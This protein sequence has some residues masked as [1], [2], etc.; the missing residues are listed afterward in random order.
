[1]KGRLRGHAL[2]ASI[3]FFVVSVASMAPASA[4][5]CEELGLEVSGPTMATSSVKGTLCREGSLEG[6]ALQLLIPGIVANRSYFDLPIQPSTYSYARKAAE[7]G[8]VSLAIDRIG[9]GS[10]DRPPFLLVDL[11]LNVSVITQVIEALRAGVVADTRFDRILIVGHSFGGLIAARIAEDGGAP[12]SGIA[13]TGVSHEFNSDVLPAAATGFYPAQLDAKFGVSV[14]VGYLTNP[15]GVRE[16]VLFQ[17]G[18]YDPAVAAADEALKDTV[19]IPELLQLGDGLDDRTTEIA[20]PVFMGLGQFDRVFCASSI[21]CSS[22]EGLRESEAPFFSP[23]ACLHTYVLANA[24]HYESLHLNAGDFHN[25]LLAWA[26]ARVGPDVAI[27][28]PGCP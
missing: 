10:S 16:D 4:V 19:T 26:N 6:K 20:V 11:D 28:S 3:F 22:A 17:P 7:S 8:Y 18:N 13:L 14:P 21:D 5:A 9:T 1:M 24:G 12:L 23:S 2:S 27:P 25:E 15:P